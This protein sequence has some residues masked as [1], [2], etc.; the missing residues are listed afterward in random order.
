M[1]E[2]TQDPH[3]TIPGGIP[4]QSHGA[5]RPVLQIVI[6]STRPGRVGL[7]VAKWITEKARSHE[8]FDIEVLDLAEIN[9][10]MFDEPKHQR[11]GDDGAFHPNDVLGDAGILMLAEL[12]RWTNALAALRRERDAGP[13]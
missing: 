1:F 7:P 12:P 9:L 3:S 8:S 5:P 13:A 6:G 2:M 11:F 10:P 4:A